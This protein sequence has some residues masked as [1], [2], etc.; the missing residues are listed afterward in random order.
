MELNKLVKLISMNMN[1]N[2]F[3]MIEVLASITLLAIAVSSFSILM[4]N[5]QINIYKRGRE[6]EITVSASKE[7]DYAISDPSYNTPEDERYTIFRSEPTEFQIFESEGTEA[8][9]G[10]IIRIEHEDEQLIT[11]MIPY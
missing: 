5:S 10:K 6:T 8:V 7:I 3:T 1:S 9:E 4:A 2:G 11:V